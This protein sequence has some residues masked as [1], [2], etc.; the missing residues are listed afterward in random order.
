MEHGL[1]VDGRDVIGEEHNARWQWISSA[2]LAFEFFRGDQAGLQQAR[3]EGAGSDV[4]GSMTWTP[5]EPSAWPNS[6]SSASL[7]EWMMK[8]TISTGV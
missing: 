8:S 3:D 1:D 5:S 2:V 7:T 4:K 6:A